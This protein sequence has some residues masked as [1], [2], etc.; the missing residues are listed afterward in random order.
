MDSRAS[1]Q[2]ESTNNSTMQVPS[3]GI[4]MTTPTPSAAA[5]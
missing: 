2:I 1:S 3:K 4:P 5:A